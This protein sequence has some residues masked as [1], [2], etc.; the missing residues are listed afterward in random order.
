MLLLL[1]DSANKENQLQE[2][3]PIVFESSHGNTGDAVFLTGEWCINFH[4]H[5]AYTK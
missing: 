3:G 4:I 2:I 5:H 1:W